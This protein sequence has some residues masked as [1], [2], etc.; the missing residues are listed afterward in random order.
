MKQRYKDSQLEIKDLRGRIDEMKE[1]IEKLEDDCKKSKLVPE[2]QT[3]VNTS[4][5]KP[6]FDLDASSMV[7]E[8]EKYIRDMQDKIDEQN[9]TINS[10]K[11]QA[12]ARS[13]SILSS[14]RNDP[15]GEEDIPPQEISDDEFGYENALKQHGECVLTST[16]TAIKGITSM[17]DEL[18]QNGF[19]PKRLGELLNEYDEKST[20][21]LLE[22]KSSKEVSCELKTPNEILQ[23]NI[24]K[25]LEER[26]HYAL[27]D[28]DRIGN[29]VT[30]NDDLSVR[31]NHLETVIK[32]KEEQVIQLIDKE[33]ISRNLSNQY[34]STLT[35][36]ESKIAEV[37][38]CNSKISATNEI[39]TQEVEKLKSDCQELQS[40]F[41]AST[42]QLKDST[43][44]EE[45]IQNEIKAY[46]T[47]IPLLESELANKDIIIHHDKSVIAIL[48]QTVVDL[49]NE[50]DNTTIQLQASNTKEENIQNEIKTYASKIPLLENELQNK[51]IIIH[52][53]KSMIAIL[54]QTVIDL[55]NKNT[56]HT[57]EVQQ[58]ISNNTSLKAD[59]NQEKE[60]RA[61][62]QKQQVNE[63]MSIEK[64]VNNLKEVNTDLESSIYKLNNLVES[65][66]KLTIKLKDELSVANIKLTDA[67]QAIEI[68]HMEKE[69]LNNELKVLVIAINEKKSSTSSDSTKLVEEV[70]HLTNAIKMQAEEFQKKE[71][72]IENKLV[73]ANATVKQFEEDNQ[74][75]LA[76]NE[77]MCKTLSEQAEEI[78]TL[79][80]GIESFKK[81]ILQSEK[82][83]K[84]LVEL[85]QQ[86]LKLEMNNSLSS[87]ALCDKDTLIEV[88]HKK[89]RSKKQ[90]IR[91]KCENLYE[92]TLSLRNDLDTL[93]SM[94]RQ[95]E[96]E[97][98]NE[99]NEM[100]KQ[101]HKA[102]L[103]SEELERKLSALL[104][105]K[106]LL[107]SQVT[108]DASKKSDEV[109]ELQTQLA[110]ITELEH[111]HQHL[112]ETEKKRFEEK[113]LIL[114]DN[115]RRSQSKIRQLTEEV[116]TFTTKIASWKGQ[117]DDLA[118]ARERI[119]Y[120]DERNKCQVKQ[121]KDNTVDIGIQYDGI[122]VTQVIT[123]EITETV[124]RRI[125]TRYCNFQ[126]LQRFLMFCQ[127]TKCY[128]SAIVVRGL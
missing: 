124:H 37:E 27:Q 79:K 46:A 30:E 70:N 62:S 55:Q 98:K 52:H 121:K 111:K 92:T 110:L 24:A 49:Q 50:F 127:E 23:E 61:T 66:G 7:E 36:L 26:L 123:E 43:I 89:G 101:L 114:R 56:V 19:T 28:S 105:E 47:K 90:K 12:D 15:D 119:R 39:S 107:L 45:N 120:L 128:H 25:E 68:S 59:I 51:D 32:D 125:P 72:E 75:F 117:Q 80:C 38:E 22:S 104:N 96:D 122:E 54:E 35:T 57:S 93:K 74:R 102:I 76:D 73:N 95:T 85:R 86:I 84:I 67:L 118:K 16:P 65:E 10:L 34:A 81:K 53:D 64:E 5:Q 4:N 126:L 44:N 100:E 6:D 88:L 31:L 21:T 58:L 99:L 113:I 9:Q 14:T 11:D 41:D 2:I 17:A 69:R 3:E 108:S 42:I 77:T 103:Q 1:Y 106:I 109:A 20:Q 83:N 33:N 71:L 48:E 60:S 116:E 29:L 115:D 78:S 94:S 91:Q 63:I 82:Q 112:N 8:Y 18:R 40:K 13:N 97:M 87:K